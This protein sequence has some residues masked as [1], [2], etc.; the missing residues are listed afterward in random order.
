MPLS[1]S[2]IDLNFRNGQYDDAATSGTDPAHFLMHFTGAD[3]STSGAGYVDATG[4][5]NPVDS[6]F[7]SGHTEIDNAQ[8]VFGGTSLLNA[9]SRGSFIM[10]ANNKPDFSFGTGDFTIDF[11]LRVSALPSTNDANLFQLTNGGSIGVLYLRLS[12]G[13]LR[14]AGSSNVDGATTLSINT[15]YHVAI[16][17]ASGTLRIFL[18]GV[19]D[20]TGTDTTDHVPGL[21]TVFGFRLDG[22]LDEYRIVSGAA[23]W[24]SGFT[25]P[26]AA[27]TVAVSGPYTNLN[28]SRASI[29][30]AKN[31]D[32]TLTQFNANVL[33]IGVGKGL[34]IEDQRTNVILDSED[35]SNS[36]VW[37]LT[38][39][40]ATANQAT[41]PNG[42]VAMDKISDGTA[43]SRHDVTHNQ[44]A[45]GQIFCTFS[46]FLKDVDRRY[47]Y[48]ECYGNNT[49]GNFSAVVDLQ[50]GTITQSGT[51]SNGTHG[52]IFTSATVEAFTNGI[53]RLTISGRTGS[54]DSQVYCTVSTCDTGTP[55]MPLTG[56]YNYTG[57]NKSIYVWGAQLELS[58]AA[59]F[60]SSYIPTS[61]ASFTRAKDLVTAIGNLNTILI[62]TPGSAVVDTIAN[63]TPVAGEYN[64]FIG[65]AGGS[66]LIGIDAGSG[67]QNTGMFSYNPSGSPASLGGV[68]LGNSLTW[69]GGAKG[70][71]AWNSSGR[72]MVGGAGTVGS[73]AS[74]FTGN[75]TGA[76]IGYGGGASSEVA[77]NYFR[78]LTVWNSKLSDP[79]LQALTSPFDSV[80]AFNMPMMGF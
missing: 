15:W 27:Y 2:S 34:L 37:T 13:N 38:G 55:T 52:E 35:F 11:R 25:P 26:S 67:L 62:G 4:R 44:I 69:T 36:G 42:A 46:V 3:A 72:S 50:T 48:I 73:D 63:R 45:L 9:V 5:H 59:S 41:A 68:V 64:R 74:N 22:W 23:I 43:N 16:T 12:G 75:L 65:D 1:G 30:Y 77:W 6:T 21:T 20:G 24:T 29:G 19:I 56:D 60:P 58:A 28:C 53:Y 39:V 78:R 18:D 32:G 49:T 33:R 76:I 10:V 71:I 40:T 31:A 14:W 8:S 57:S 79:T 61:G 17:R 80:P 7:G 54:T 66:E 70:G 51:N 47:A